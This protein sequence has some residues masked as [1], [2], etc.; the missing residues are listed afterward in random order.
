MWGGKKRLVRPLLPLAVCALSSGWVETEERRGSVAC[1]DSS[2]ACHVERR[3]GHTV[4]FRDKEEF[5]RKRSAFIE[6]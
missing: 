2:R 3:D 1:N 4:V 5:M 6:E